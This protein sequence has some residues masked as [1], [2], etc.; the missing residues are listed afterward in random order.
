[1]AWVMKFDAA[2]SELPLRVAPNLGWPSLTWKTRRSVESQ[3]VWPSISYGL[4]SCRS[5]RSALAATP[6][7]DAVSATLTSG[8]VKSASLLIEIGYSQ[9]DHMDARFHPPQTGAPA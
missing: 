5:S 8:A 1:M 6:P 3:T 4:G 9:C 2:D 7:M